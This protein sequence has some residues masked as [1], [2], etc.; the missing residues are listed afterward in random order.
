MKK[1]S[2]KTMLLSETLGLGL[3]V[4]LFWDIL[5]EKSGFFNRFNLRNWRDVYYESKPDSKAREKSFEKISKICLSEEDLFMWVKMY[6]R[7][8]AAEDSKLENMIFEK[9]AAEIEIDL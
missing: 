7:A 8:R 4:V 1:L 6:R 5:A 2:L 9:L 3:M